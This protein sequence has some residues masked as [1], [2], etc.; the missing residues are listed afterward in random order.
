MIRRSLIMLA[1]VATVGQSSAQILP[2]WIDDNCAS[3][4]ERM[5][6]NTG[7]YIL[8]KGEEELIGR[9]WLAAH[10]S[11][12]Y[13]TARE[14]IRAQSSIRGVKRRRTPKVPAG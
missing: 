11:V 14:N 4:L 6:A 5:S 8:E 12:F 13:R 7:V 10:N 9:A 3:C 1:L 2:E